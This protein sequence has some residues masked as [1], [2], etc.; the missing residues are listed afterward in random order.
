MKNF[1]TVTRTQDEQQIEIAVASIATLEAFPHDTTFITFKELH[2]R[3]FPSALIVRESLF[4]LTLEITAIT[5]L[6]VSS[7]YS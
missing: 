3:S 2:P 5:A 7:I 6:S 4:K 1:I